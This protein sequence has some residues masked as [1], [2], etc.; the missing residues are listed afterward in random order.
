MSELKR[1]AV[2]A[3]G[4]GLPA[5]YLLGALTWRQTQWAY[6]ALALAVTGLE[7][8]RLVLGYEWALFDQLARDY[9][10]S[11]VAGYALYAYSQLAVA[12]VFSPL[13]A[14]PGMLMLTL[15][16][17]IAGYLG[18]NDPGTTK[19]LAVLGAMF[20]VSGGLAAPFTARLA[21]SLA[22]GLA[23]AAAGGV[24]ATVADGVKPVVAGR[25]IDD[26]AT[27]PPAACL[28]IA[29]VAAVAGVPTATILG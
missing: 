1:R 27:I 2:H 18:T 21:S 9:E 17:P 4:T 23:A 12:L 11:N 15:G 7:F 25:V 10:R 26:N 3:T 24:A 8:V 13:V 6:V 5:L 19:R 22:V 16:D 28:A 14:I 29:A 20:L